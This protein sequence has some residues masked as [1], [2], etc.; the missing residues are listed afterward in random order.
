MCCKKLGYRQNVWYFYV[1]V[2]PL[3]GFILHFPHI[4]KHEEISIYFFRLIGTFSN[5]WMQSKPQKSNIGHV[6]IEFFL[7]LQHD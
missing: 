2:L 1:N 6:Y 4:K 5:A 7:N 3:H